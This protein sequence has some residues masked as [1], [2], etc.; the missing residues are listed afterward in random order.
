[1]EFQNLTFCPY[2]IEAIEP[3]MLEEEELNFLNAY[4]KT[5]Y[6]T[7]SPYLDRKDKA[8]LKQVTKALKK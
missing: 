1:M 5:V 3:S 4:H 8:W 6:E 7:L 2:E